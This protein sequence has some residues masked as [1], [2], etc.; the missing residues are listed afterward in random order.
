MVRSG[1][2]IPQYQILNDLQQ[3]M[4]NLYNEALQTVQRFLDKLYYKQLL[5]KLNVIKRI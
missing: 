3:E 2:G 1:K 4:K 5:L